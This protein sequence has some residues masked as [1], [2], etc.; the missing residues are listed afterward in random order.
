[1]DDKALMKKLRRRVVKVRD[2]PAN[3]C[4]YSRHLHLMADALSRG[5][6]YP[7]LQEE[8]EHCA[9]AMLVVLAEL[10][11][12]RINDKARRKRTARQLAKL[13]AATTPPPEKP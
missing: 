10:W 5:K 8:P 1:M 4:P 9:A 6:P 2:F 12:Y 3:T 11:E 13:E 7:M